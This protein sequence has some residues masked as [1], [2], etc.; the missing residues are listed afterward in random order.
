MTS[1]IKCRLQYECKIKKHS[2][3]FVTKKLSEK[4]GI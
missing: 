4:Y 3:K 1:I 2:D